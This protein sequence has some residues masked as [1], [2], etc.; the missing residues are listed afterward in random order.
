MPQPQHASAPATRQNPASTVVAP[1][2]LGSGGSGTGGQYAQ[3]QDKGNNSSGNHSP[4]HRSETKGGRHVGR[5][6][7]IVFLLLLAAAYGAGAFA[8]S[9]ICYPGTSIAGVDVSWNDREQATKRAAKAAQNYSLTIDG[10]G[11]SWSFKPERGG[12]VFDAAAAVDRVLA[13][14]EPL[15]WPMRLARAFGGAAKPDADHANGDATVD[16]PKQF[17]RDAFCDEL[18]GAIGAFNDGR[19]GTFDAAGAYDEQTSAFTVEKARSNQKINEQALVNDALAAVAT[20]SPTVTVEEADLEPL[21]G[22][23]TDEE[24]QT[25]CDAANAL[26]GT[27]V[28]L[29]LGNDIVA[30]LDGKQLAQW[31]T[32]DEALAPTLDTN[33]VGAW[34]KQLATQIDTKGTTRTYTRPDGKQVSVSGG[35]YGWVSDEAA[36]VKQLQDAVA[37]KQVG[38]IAI[39]TKQTAARFTGAGQ[40]DWGAYIDVD[41]SEQHARYYDAAGTLVWESPIISGNPNTGHATPLGVYKLNSKSRNMTLVG[42]DEDDDGEPDYKTPV[43]YWMPFVGNAIGLHDANWQSAAAFADPSAHTYRGS[44]GCVNLP[45]DKAAELYGIVEPGVCVVSHT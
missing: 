4:R 9:R 8:F 45:P 20:L 1:I 19:T 2:P 29:K 5:T 41:L 7:A 40:A 44:H 14:N 22:G 17:D 3:R 27:N 25:A 39:P 26:I 33:Q 30:T 43:D 36:L 6:V 18:A 12:D 28:N 31:M 13:G 38:D 23:A 35:P 24:L 16:L 37:N 11:F 32:F 15:L 34:A 21:A 42:L 10:H